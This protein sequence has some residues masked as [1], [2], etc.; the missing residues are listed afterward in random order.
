MAWF[1]WRRWLRSTSQS[2]PRV[3]HSR[4]S[5]RLLV[6]QLE[7]R[8]APATFIWT[9]AAS[10]SWATG[11]NWQGGIAPPSASGPLDDLV[12]PSTATRFSAI[13]DILGATFNSI[14]LSGS[15]YT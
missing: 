3:P 1:N 2:R 10:T 15:N 7:S 14:T 13:N 12:F 9:G 8:L 5:R 4:T 11:A 6:E